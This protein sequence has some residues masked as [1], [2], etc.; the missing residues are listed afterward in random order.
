M[1]SSLSEIIFRTVLKN[2]FYNGSNNAKT[3]TLK[4]KQR[5]LPSSRKFK[6]SLPVMADSTVSKDETRLPFV[7]SLVSLKK[8][9]MPPMS[10]RS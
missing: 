5:I 4:K 3:E 8:K 7:K 9:K 10:L 1:N 2:H 6:L